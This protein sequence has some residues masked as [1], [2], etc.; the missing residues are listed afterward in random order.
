METLTEPK[1]PAYKGI[2]SSVLELAEAA[3]IDRTGIY[4]VKPTWSKPKEDYLLKRQ[5]E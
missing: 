1:K 4:V 2:L 5:T 3:F